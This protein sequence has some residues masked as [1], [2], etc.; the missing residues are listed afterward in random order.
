VFEAFRDISSS[1]GRLKQEQDKFILTMPAVD[2]EEELT[3]QTRLDDAVAQ[4]RLE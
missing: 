4:A 1:V 2:L 3:I